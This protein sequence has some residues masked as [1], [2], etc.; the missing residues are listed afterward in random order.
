MTRRDD[1]FDKFSSQEESDS[2]RELVRCAVCSRMVGYSTTHPYCPMCGAKLDFSTPS[3]SGRSEDI[4][5]GRDR[6]PVHRRATFVERRRCNRIP[7]RDVKACINT[8]GFNSVIGEM[9]NVSRNGMC[10]QNFRIS[11]VL[12]LWFRLR[13]TTP[14]A[15]K[16]SFRRSGRL[17]AVHRVRHI[18]IRH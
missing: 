10:L 13:R 2:S 11:S 7:C 12:K 17:G 15:V 16:I 14:R 5:T 3:Y 4:V 9:P 1:E 6:F 8:G 18:R